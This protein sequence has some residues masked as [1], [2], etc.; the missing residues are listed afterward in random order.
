VGRIEQLGT[1][2]SV[3]DNPTSSFVYHFLG[4]TNA[5]PDGLVRPHEFRVSS[6]PRAGYR[7]GTLK[8]MRLVGATARLEVDDQAVSS[9]IEI[10]ISKGQLEGQLQLGAPIYYLL[11]TL[12]TFPVVY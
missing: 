6:V 1:P 7:Q 12:R 4:R 8:F 11:Q 10:E 2:E 5:L 9:P 3:Y